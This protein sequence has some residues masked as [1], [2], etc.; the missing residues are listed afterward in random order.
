EGI[1]LARLLE[2]QGPLKLR[3]VAT[4]L[5]QACDAIAE[6]HALG[7][8]HRDLKPSNLFLTQRRDG[9]P[10][11]KLLDF[12]IS[13]FVASGTE[14]LTSTGDGVGTPTYASPEQ[15][16][17]AKNVDAGTDV[18]ALGVILYRMLTNEFPFS[19]ETAAAILLDIMSS[20]PPRL[21]GRGADVPAAVDALLAR[22]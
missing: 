16:V 13:K 4:Y 7:I 17:S 5:V 22:C 14:Q 15:H 1:D 19:G 18:W 10:H 2:E 9:S 6:A 20:P 12:G 21:R 8:V 3:D 11:I